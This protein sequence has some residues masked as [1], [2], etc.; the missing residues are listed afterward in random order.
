MHSCTEE[1]TCTL[2]RILELRVYWFIFISVKSSTVLKRPLAQMCF[3]K[4]CDGGFCPPHR[5]V[6][7]VFTIILK[8]IL[9][10]YPSLFFPCFIPCLAC[11]HMD[12][13]KLLLIT[14]DVSSSHLTAKPDWNGHLLNKDAMHCTTSSCAAQA[15]SVAFLPPLL[16]PFH[17]VHDLLRSAALSKTWK[18]ISPALI[19][20]SIIKTDPCFCDAT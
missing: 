14:D 4:L 17:C 1:T 15:D 5:L 19:A 20:T 10:S 12:F 9:F 7:W 3:P 11:I 18:Y 16:P 13:F 2:P 8:K 6:A